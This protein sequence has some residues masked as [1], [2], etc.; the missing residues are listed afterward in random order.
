MKNY[1][2][3][4]RYAAKAF[5]RGR[6]YAQLDIAKV[7]SECEKL[8]GELKANRERLAQMQLSGE[9]KAEELE[10]IRNQIAADAVRYRDLKGALDEEEGIQAG[11]VAAQFNRRNEAAYA[12]ARGGLIRAMINRTAPDARILAALSV[13]ITTGANPGNGLLPVTVSSDLIHDIY[14]EDEMLAEIT[15]TTVSGLRLPK[16]TT[17]E[18]VTDEA[19][20]AGTAATEHDTADDVI[21]F[22][23]YPGRD[24]VSVPGGV[25]RGTNTDL[26]GY[27]T[28]KLTEI[29]Q[30]RMLRRVFATAA[31]GEYKHMS[32]YDATVGVKTVS[33]ATT[34]KAICAALAALPV[35]ARR[36]A[37]VVMTPSTYFEMVQ[38]L[39]NGAAALF[40]SPEQAML[41]FKVVLCD[42]ASK[43]LVG[44]L[45]V[46]HAN[47]DEPLAIK[48]DEDV[49]TDIVKVVALSDYDI[50]IT[51]A[52][53]LRIAEV[54]AAAA[55]SEGAD[56]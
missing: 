33:G 17:T 24:K 7:R 22:G 29:H 47:Y 2:Q 49:D 10:G 38:E 26:D 12:A 14:G 23:R 6:V 21:T 16:A 32:V 48:G 36:A 44:D 25:L 28:G 53:R 31:T 50:R 9:A 37:K 20:G 45:K 13:P 40:S 4:M 27:F 19:V 18:N 41:G 56:A 46:I 8:A 54:T 39:A 43:I 11:R 15:V 34:Y 1:K 55:A 5:A 42:Y 30:N 51:D 35:A 52:N 3:M